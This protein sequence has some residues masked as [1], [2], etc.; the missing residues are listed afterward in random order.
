MPKSGAF[1]ADVPKTENLSHQDVT[2]PWLDFDPKIPENGDFEA[3][4]DAFSPHLEQLQAE[5]AEA[6]RQARGKNGDGFATSDHPNHGEGA[7]KTKSVE[8]DPRKKGER[9]RQDEAI[10]R[11]TKSP[12]R[13][14][15]L[16]AFDKGQICVLLSLGVSRRQA[17]AYVSSSPSTIAREMKRDPQFAHTIRRCGQLA[18]LEPLL[19]I[20][21]S[22]KSD[23]RAAAWLTNYL[24]KRQTTELTAEDM[25]AA[26][27]EHSE[28][29]KGKRSA[30]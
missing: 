7:P 20:V 16:D 15:A 11:Y 30:K 9:N 2:P 24:E 18:Q 14:R 13:P 23:W 27:A 10:E 12:G 5:M 22:A 3:K 26:L 28:K 25:M 8:K 21:E 29:K 6:F 19:K 17:A 4:P 1:T